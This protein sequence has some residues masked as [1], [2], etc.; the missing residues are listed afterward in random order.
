VHY[1]PRFVKA[2]CRKPKEVGEGTVRKKG[3]GSPKKV[4]CDEAQ[5]IPRRE[6][7]I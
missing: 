5:S 7:Y 1:D 4:A 2:K 6:E 3:R